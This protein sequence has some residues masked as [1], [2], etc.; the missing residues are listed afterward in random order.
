VNNKVGNLWNR[1]FEMSERIMD[2]DLTEEELRNELARM[3]GLYKAS[4]S[5]IDMTNA[6]TRMRVM[7][8]NEGITLPEVFTDMGENPMPRPAHMPDVPV[9]TGRRP[10]LL[11]GKRGGE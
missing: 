11:P 3:D 2:A 8:K 7:E 4:K 10:P 9:E 6:V 1:I 5:V